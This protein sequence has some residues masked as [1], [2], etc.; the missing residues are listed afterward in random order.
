MKL[1]ETSG[2]ERNIDWLP[3]PHPQLGTWPAIQECSLT[4]NHT[5]D[6]SVHRLALNPL[7]HASQGVD[8]L[9]LIWAPSESSCF[10]RAGLGTEVTICIRHIF[11]GSRDPRL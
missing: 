5:S 7:S 1:R 8:G 6:L 10:H 2:C 3:L 4:G 11:V 9:L